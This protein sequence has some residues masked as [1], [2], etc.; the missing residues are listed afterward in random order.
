MSNEVIIIGKPNVGKSSIF[1]GIIKKKMALVDDHPGLTRDIR[2]KKIALW[3]KEIELID[4]PGLIL[5]K[6]QFEK[7]INNFTKKR[8]L[9]IL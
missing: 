4:S 7:K 6:N 2:K 8:W 9:F 5:S 1:N 3:D